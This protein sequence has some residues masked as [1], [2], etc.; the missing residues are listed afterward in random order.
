M[1][2]VEQ[3]YYEADRRHGSIDSLQSI[4]WRAAERLEALEA[5][6]RRIKDATTNEIRAGDKGYVSRYGIHGIATKALEGSGNVDTRR[7]H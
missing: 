4:E 3:M 7:S 5:A 2:L 1:P 6:L